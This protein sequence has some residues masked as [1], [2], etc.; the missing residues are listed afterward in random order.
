MSRSSSMGRGE[1]DLST[2]II[3]GAHSLGFCFSELSVYVNQYTT[4]GFTHHNLHLSESLV[5]LRG[6]RSYFDFFIQFVDDNTLNKQN[7]RL[8]T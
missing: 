5:I 3:R 7:S 2:S 6:I 4:N 1:L 8:P